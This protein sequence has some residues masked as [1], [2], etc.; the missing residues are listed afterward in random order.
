MSV[1]RKSRKTASAMSAKHAT[2]SHQ[3][4]RVA[5]RALVPPTPRS[6]SLAA[7]V[8]TPLYNTTDPQALRKALR[9][10]NLWSNFTPTKIPCSEVRHSFGD[11]GICRSLPHLLGA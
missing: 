3:A 6:C 11:G 1:R 7:S 8:T 4:S 5:L 2:H 9:S 10:S